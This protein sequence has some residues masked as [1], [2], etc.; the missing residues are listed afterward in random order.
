MATSFSF[1]NAASAALGRR[2]WSW[3]EAREAEPMVNPAAATMAT[4]TSEV[5]NSFLFFKIMAFESSNLN[6]IG[7]SFQKT[8]TLT[9]ETLS[10]QSLKGGFVMTSAAVFYGI[11]HPVHSSTAN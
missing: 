6:F 2:E 7:F 3:A 10:V 8:L 4:A 11:F 1:R 9:M 5:T